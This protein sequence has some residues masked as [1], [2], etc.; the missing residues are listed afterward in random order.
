MKLEPKF[1][2]RIFSL[3]FSTLRIF[4]SLMGKWE[5]LAV[6]I[7]ILVLFGNLWLSISNFYFSHTK[8]A[9]SSGGSYTEGMLGQPRLINPILATSAT[10]QA[11]VKLI[12]SG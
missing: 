5:K 3:N 10:D 2:N 8:A 9:P 4:F 7:L 1:K 6:I 12:Y 11:L